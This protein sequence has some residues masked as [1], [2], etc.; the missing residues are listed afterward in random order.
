MAGLEREMRDYEA[1]FMDADDAIRLFQKLVDTGIAWRLDERYQR[2]ARAL[3]EAG[4][5]F[6]ARGEAPLEAPEETKAFED[7]AEWLAFAEA[8]R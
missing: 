4:M 5:I 2:T 7:P 3:L 1:G 8:T 6:P